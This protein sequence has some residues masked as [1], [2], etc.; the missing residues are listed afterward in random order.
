MTVGVSIRIENRIDVPLWAPRTSC[1]VARGLFR[2]CS[3]TPTPRTFEDEK[4]AF[5]EM[6]DDLASKYAGEYVA[7]KDGQVVGHGPTRS[8]VAQ[9]F[10]R[11]HQGPVCI[12]F[13]GPKRIGHQLSPFR[14]HARVS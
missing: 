11:E 4:A 1:V 9:A 6:F 2:W 7:V 10:F 13:V 12:G 3:T 8:E 14:A 5:D